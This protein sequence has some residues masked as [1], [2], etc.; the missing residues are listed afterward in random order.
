LK[1]RNP[2]H[3]K[4]DYGAVFENCGFDVVVGNPP[5]IED[6]KYNQQ[7][8]KVIESL[9]AQNNNGVW[10]YTDE[11][12]IYSSNQCGNTHAYFI[13]RSLE[14]L[15]DGGKFG[16]IVPVALVSTDRMNSIREVLHGDSSSISYLILMIDLQRYSE[17]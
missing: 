5:Y 10:N 7:E 11:P 13:E 1:I 14:V 9:V 6:G 16:F 3:W 15:K 17:E 12:L 2:F 4:V 8:L